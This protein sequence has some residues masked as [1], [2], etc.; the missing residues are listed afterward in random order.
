MPRDDPMTIPLL[1]ARIRQ[2][3]N[4]S[5]AKTLVF[6]ASNIDIDLL[7]PLYEA[8][9]RIGRVPALDV[10]V[11]LRG[12]E[13]NAA[14]RLALLLHEFTDRL[15]FIVPHHCESSGTLMSFAARQIVAGPLAV[16]SP[17]DP[18]LNGA[19]GNGSAPTALSSQDIRLFATMSQAWFGFDEETAR[20][21]ALSLLCDNIFPTTLTSFY[22][23][24]QELE[25]IGD[26]LLTLHMPSATAEARSAIVR[27]L[28]YDFHSHNFALTG[29]DLRA[30]GLP[31]V[32]DAGIEELA[33]DIACDIRRLIG[34]ESRASLQG[35][36]R[37]AIIAT[38]DAIGLRRR[39]REMPSGTWEMLD[40]A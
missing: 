22:R 26:E 16:F 2:L 31:A 21:K 14:R 12:G 38:T 29:D 11:Y 1:S 13:V 34:P 17:I 9:R 36:W 15:R 4:E 18:H 32:R 27:K 8:L 28:L 40:N 39:S 7:P 5:G 33:W 20:A 35:D 37:D 10:V 24:T 6:G 30:A 19:E 25:V 23:A 3:E